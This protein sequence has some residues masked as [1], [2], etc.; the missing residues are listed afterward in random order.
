MNNNKNFLNKTVKTFITS[1][2]V[3]VFV[4]GSFYFL[5]SD[6]SSSNPTPKSAGDVKSDTS[7][8]LV[9]NDDATPSKVETSKS[10]KSEDL[11]IAKTT[12]TERNVLGAQTTN[13]VAQLPTD[14]IS[15]F[16]NQVVQTTP[17]ASITGTLPSALTTTETGIASGVPKTGNES[18]YA[19]LGIFSLVTGFLI[20]NGK[21]L[22]MSS[23]E[24]EI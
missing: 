4:F 22:A 13:L 19:I 17:A 7:K 1:L 15:P 20:S 14:N 16:V 3:S 6:N 24:R 8:K 23:F 5:L 21:S 9:V 2:G 18:L 12:E 10:K 11:A